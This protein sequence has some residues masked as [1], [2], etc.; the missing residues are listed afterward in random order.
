[1]LLGSAMAV[2]DWLTD[3]YVD[4]RVTPKGADAVGPLPARVL[5]PY[6]VLSLAIRLCRRFLSPTR[7]KH[8][9]STSSRSSTP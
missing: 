3:S 8:P 2:R 7:S 9:D 4:F 6:A 1:M 5:F